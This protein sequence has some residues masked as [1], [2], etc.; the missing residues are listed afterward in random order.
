MADHSGVKLGRRRIARDRRTLALHKYLTR[1][2]PAPPDKVDWSHGVTDWGMML[3]DQLGCCTIAGA[4]HAVQAWTANAGAMQ[5]IADSDIERFYSLWDGYKPGDETTDNGGIELDVLKSWR[6][7]GLAGHTLEAFA[8]ANPRNLTEIRQA[9]HLFGGV[10]IGLNL[11]QTA[12][13][14]DVWDTVTFGGDSAEPGSWGGHCVHVIEYDERS[15]TCITWGA[16]KTMTV[17]FWGR[18]CDESYA[19]IGADW[20]GAKGAPNGFAHDQLLADLKSIS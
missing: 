4:A 17:P 10:Y 16:L 11:P 13:A 12:Q 18:Y 19:L 7:D 1:A 20:F 14:Q 6:H 9:I 3:N 2:L 15:F 5:T 8:S